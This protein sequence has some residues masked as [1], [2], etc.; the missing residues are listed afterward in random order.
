MAK[1]R[2]QECDKECSRIVSPYFYMAFDVPLGYAD[3]MKNPR[4]E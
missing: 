4:F 3:F 1:R 2:I